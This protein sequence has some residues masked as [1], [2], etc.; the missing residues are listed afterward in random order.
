MKINWNP[1]YKTILNSDSELWMKLIYACP[2]LQPI[3][4]FSSVLEMLMPK[5]VISTVKATIYW[6]E[7]VAMVSLEIMYIN[8]VGSGLLG[9]TRVWL[10][11]LPYLATV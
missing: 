8:W 9:S 4:H 7:K 5:G 2:I 11:G 6:Q 1:F 10:Q 3:F